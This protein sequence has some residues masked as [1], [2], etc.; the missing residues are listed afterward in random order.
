LL[1]S[2]FTELPFSVMSRLTGLHF[3][4][5]NSCVLSKYLFSLD[6]P[7]QL[8]VLCFPEVCSSLVGTSATELAVLGSFLAISLIYVYVGS[9]VFI[10]VVIRICTDVSEQ[11]ITYIFRVEM[12]RV[13]KVL[14]IRWLG[15]HE[16]FSTLK[17]QLIRS[18]ETSNYTAL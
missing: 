4:K 2:H 1:V 15:T 18:S 7:K 11:H 3:Y 16:P 14:Y 6:K 13:R 5:A 9:E 8:V 10:A 17:K 12:N